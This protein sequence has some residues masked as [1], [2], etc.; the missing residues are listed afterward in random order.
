M[1]ERLDSI[2][3]QAFL[4]VNGAH[5]P[6]ADPIMWSV[7]DMITWFPLYAFFLFLLQRRYDWRGLL[8]CLPVIALM[9]LC[10]DKGSV[11]LFKETVQR[12][13]PCHEPALAGMVHTVREHCGGSF[14]FVSSH[15][16]NHFAIAAFMSV[17]LQRSPRWAPFALVLWA[18]FVA[19]SRI[20]LGVHYP[21]DV[22]VGAL[23][24]GAIGLVFG[25]VLHR[26]VLRSLGS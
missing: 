19:Y 26:S 13:R 18:A 17:L 11:V 10:S 3:R 21:G 25:S 16:S 2:D 9:V 4:A 5:A 23:Y 15:A 7:S 24:G 8:W 1:W 22:L 6:W 20:Y 14:G 12:L